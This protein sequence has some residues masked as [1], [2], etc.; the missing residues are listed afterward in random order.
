[1]SHMILKFK[2]SIVQHVRQLNDNFKNLT[3]DFEITLISKS[4]TTTWRFYFIDLG[5]AS[6]V[7]HQP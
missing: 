2:K 6:L 5:V 7:F 4:H 1:M 3:Y